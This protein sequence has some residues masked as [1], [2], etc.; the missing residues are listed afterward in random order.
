MRTAPRPWKKLPSPLIIAHRGV[1]ARYLENTLAA[2]QGALDTGADMIELDLH[3]TRDGE[4]VVIHDA[5][6]ARVA[7]EKV[8]V[9]RAGLARLQAVDLKGGH[10]VPTLE[11]VLNLVAHRIPLNLELKAKGTGV[12]LARFLTRRSLWEG[13]LV[14]S[15]KAKEVEGFHRLCTRVPVARIY[16]RIS[17]ED[18]ARNARAGHYSIHVDHRYLKEKTV[19]LAHRLGL[20]VFTFTVDEPQEMVKLFSWR[21][22]GIFTNDPAQALEVARKHG[23][24]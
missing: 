12:A 11:E 4:L 20:R 14:S 13:L 3:L 17:V 1:S 18:V 7:E 6:T 15:Y 23:Y 21:V 16:T 24:R 8:K 10:Q 2:F 9:R 5:T 19:K 22:D